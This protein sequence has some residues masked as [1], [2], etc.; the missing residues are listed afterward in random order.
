MC[1]CDVFDIMVDGAYNIVYRF[2]IISSGCLQETRL[3][4]KNVLLLEVLSVDRPGI[5]ISFQLRMFQM[6][7]G[8]Q[9]HKHK[10]T[11]TL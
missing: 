11:I 2:G 4:N 3:V 10:H 6:L 7:I 5:L 1:S 9:P 8:G